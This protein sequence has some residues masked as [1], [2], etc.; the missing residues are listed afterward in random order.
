MSRIRPLMFLVAVLALCAAPARSA[1]P[2]QVNVILALTGTG[3]LL[4]QSEQAALQVLEKRVNATG[5]INGRP[6][7]MVYFDD[8]SNPQVSVQLASQLIAKNVQIILGSSL[9]GA[10]NAIAPLAK[11]GPVL[12]CLSPG[13][14]PPPGSFAFTAGSSSHDVIAATVRYFHD[15]NL[16]R[17][18]WISSTDASGQ[19]GETAFDLALAMPHNSG[20][21]VVAREHFN[22]T[23]LNVGAQMARIKA[24]N[25]DAIF[26]WSSG[27][28]MGTI[29]HAVVDTGLDKIPLE[30]SAANLNYRQL[31]DYGPMLPALAITGTNA[32]FSADLITDRAMKQAVGDMTT[33]IAAAGLRP[34]YLQSLAWDAGSIVVS[35]LRKVGPDASAEQ[36]RTYIANLRGFAGVNGVY[37]FRANPQRGLDVRGA[38]MVRW[39][40]AG[41]RFVGVSRSGGIPVP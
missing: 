7:Q 9:V 16:R 23:D 32:M 22:T 19:D 20:M 3:T 33:A 37:D 31:K 36:L 29:L 8:Q 10:C 26:T 25:P 24:A 11:N 2:V 5:G 17:M 21:T 13:L 6:L 4:G 35:A 40:S 1:D 39:D 27:T 14:H 18:A 34:D 15:R 12:Y 38:Y 28:P 41:D 30:I